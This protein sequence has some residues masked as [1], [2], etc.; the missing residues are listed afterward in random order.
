MHASQQ[1][2]T[3]EKTGRGRSETSRG[4]RALAT[5]TTEKRIRAHFPILAPGR[6]GGNRPTSSRF[7]A[8]LL[9]RRREKRTFI[10]TKLVA[11]AARGFIKPPPSPPPLT[12]GVEN[13]ETRRPKRAGAISLK[14]L[15]NLFA[16][17]HE[18]RREDGGKECD[19]SDTEGLQQA[20]RIP[21]TRQKCE[22][23]FAS[24]VAKTSRASNAFAR[25]HMAANDW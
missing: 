23:L 5:A 20:C 13:V 17:A 4:D 25:A 8:P 24:G 18:K 6:A 2:S 15:T 16:R 14:V 19:R 10:A 9:F 3:S 7:L 12:A 22:R 11:T 21:V 1:S